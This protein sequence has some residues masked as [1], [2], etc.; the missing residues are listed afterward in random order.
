[1]KNWEYICLYRKNSFDIMALHF[2]AFKIVDLVACFLVHD[3]TNLSV[4]PHTFIVLWPVYYIVGIGLP[5]VLKK[6]YTCVK[7]FLNK[8]LMGRVK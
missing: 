1:M 7:A 4:F 3:F 6:M 8:K 2:L 5:L